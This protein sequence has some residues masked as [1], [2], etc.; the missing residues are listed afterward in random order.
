MHKATNTRAGTSATNTGQTCRF[1]SC[2]IDTRTPV[3]VGNSRIVDLWNSGYRTYSLIARSG[4][5]YTTNDN[6]TIISKRFGSD[7]ENET[8]LK[9]SRYTTIMNSIKAGLKK[10]H[11]CRVI[12][13]ATINECRS[14][15]VEVEDKTPDEILDKAGAK[16]VNFARKCRIKVKVRTTKKEREKMRRQGKRPRKFMYVRSKVYVVQC[17]KASDFEWGLNYPYKY[18]KKYN[19]YVK[20]YCKEKNIKYVT[21]DRDPKESE[22]REDGLHF[23]IAKSGYNAL[24]WK[25]IKSLPFN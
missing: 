18:V 5:Q 9:K 6:L 19:K 15:R 2:S 3:I 4:G 21:L 1:R 24:M 22:F 12:V 16:V 10:K 20:S 23:K 11:K 25:K 7:L 13:L 8:S 14:D 17:V